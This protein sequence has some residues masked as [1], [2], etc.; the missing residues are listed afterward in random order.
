[1]E[2]SSNA[3]K[4]SSNLDLGYPLVGHS[5]LEHSTSIFMYFYI[6]LLFRSSSTASMMRAE[7]AVGVWLAVG[8]CYT[9]KLNILA[10][11]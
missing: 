4:G 8:G 7:S 1:M 10:H 11:N 2:G 9:N 3:G 6:C 5:R